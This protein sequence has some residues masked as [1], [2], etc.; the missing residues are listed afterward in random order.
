MHEKP[1]F[2]VVFYRE[3]LGLGKSGFASFVGNNPKSNKR[4]FQ[5][6]ISNQNSIYKKGIFF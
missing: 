3:S 2:K 6:G 4:K 5:R 1:S